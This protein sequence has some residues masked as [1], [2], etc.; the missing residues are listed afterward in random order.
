VIAARV[1]RRYI[2]PVV[3]AILGTAGTM[4][5]LPGPADAGV[6][7]TSSAGYGLHASA[8]AGSVNASDPTAIVPYAD[9]IVTKATVDL[10]GVDA[11]ADGEPVYPGT[12]ASLLPVVLFLAGAP[13]APVGADVAATAHPP[14]SQHDSVTLGAVMLGPLRLDGPSGTADAVIGDHAVAQAQN[15]GISGI[16]LGTGVPLTGTGA[17][18]TTKAPKPG[19]ASVASAESIA[20]LGAV[21]VVAR[22]S[23]FPSPHAEVVLVQPDGS[24]VPITAEGVAVANGV[25]RGTA[26]TTSSSARAGATFEHP[27]PNGGIVR[28][29]IVSTRADAVGALVVSALPVV[30]ALGPLASSASADD[31]LSGSLSAS[32]GFSAA[33]VASF[34]SPTVALNEGRPVVRAAAR[35]A[36]FVRRRGWLLGSL[37]LACLFAGS[38]VLAAGRRMLAP[39]VVAQESRVRAAQAAASDHLDRD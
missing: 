39:Q 14:E 12:A 5:A 31:A 27:A 21:K 36:S 11:Y 28:I 38:A 15:S 25:L 26:E 7:A 1:L 30:G 24:A 13:P 4:L 8:E 33:P 37:F 6:S 20:D 3:G 34:R 18:A 17:T 23:V 19:T 22:S 16:D 29:T 9:Q 35:P 10:T 32:G 2:G